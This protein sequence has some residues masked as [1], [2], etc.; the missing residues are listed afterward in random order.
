LAALIISYKANSKKLEVL[1]SEWLNEIAIKF[2]FTRVSNL[3]RDYKISEDNSSNGTPKIFFP[4]NIREMTS[5]S[6]IYNYGLN[7][8]A[9]LGLTNILNNFEEGGVITLHD[10]GLFLKGIRIQKKLTQYDLEIITGVSGITL[11]RLETGTLDHRIILADIII[12]DKALEQNGRLLSFAWYGCQFM[13][14]FT[15]MTQGSLLT[16]YI[17]VATWSKEDFQLATLFLKVF[18]WMELVNAED[19]SWGQAMERIYKQ[20]D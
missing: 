19:S 5:P 20:N 12:L 2:E 6:Q 3:I 9:D 11:R 17:P 18:R 10:I 7:Y 14:E 16:K 8:P 13:E 15:E 4:L 1:L